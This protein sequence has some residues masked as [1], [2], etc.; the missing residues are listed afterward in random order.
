MNQTSNAGDFATIYQ[1][2]FVNVF[3]NA[4]NKEEFQLLFD[5]AMTD[6]IETITKMVSKLYSNSM[7]HLLWTK[8]SR[9]EFLARNIP[10]AL[11]YNIDNLLQLPVTVSVINPT[12]LTII[13][14]ANLPPTTA[15]LVQTYNAP[16]DLGFIEII[17]EYTQKSRAF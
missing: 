16:W 11:N 10:N 15:T 13:V 5:A 7:S 9:K 8:A 3:R 14:V 2:K 4:E 6:Y 17:I 12:N 1:Y